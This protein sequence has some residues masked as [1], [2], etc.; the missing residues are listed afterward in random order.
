MLVEDLSDSIVNLFGYYMI[1]EVLLGLGLIF[2]REFLK[3]GMYYYYVLMNNYVVD[4]MIYMKV[5]IN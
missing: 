3:D 2:D 4:I 5:K 1:F